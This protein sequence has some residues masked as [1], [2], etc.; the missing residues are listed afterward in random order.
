MDVFNDKMAEYLSETIKYVETVYK[1][2]EIYSKKKDVFGKGKDRLNFL[3]VN[4]LVREFRNKYGCIDI[5]SLSKKLEKDIKSIGCVDLVYVYAVLEKLDNIIK[6]MS[7]AELIEFMKTHPNVL[8]NLT[9]HFKDSKDF[10]IEQMYD[11]MFKNPSFKVNPV[12]F[13]TLTL[14][15]TNLSDDDIIEITDGC[16][17][18]PFKWNVYITRNLHKKYL[19]DNMDIFKLIYTNAASASKSQLDKTN[20]ITK[21]I[22]GTSDLGKKQFLLR[23][24]DYMHTAP[25][26]S[27]DTN[28]NKQLNLDHSDKLYLFDHSALYWIF[29]F[30]DLSVFMVGNEGEN[31][32][33]TEEYYDYINTIINAY[34]VNFV[35]K[36]SANTKY[37]SNKI[38]SLEIYEKIYMLHKSTHIFDEKNDDIVG[39]LINPN[40]TIKYPFLPWPLDDTRFY[41]E[42]GVY[43]S[44]IDLLS[45]YHTYLFNVKNTRNM[46][47]DKIRE[48]DYIISPIVSKYYRYGKLRR[49]LLKMNYS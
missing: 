13:E 15:D 42:F 5:I 17:Y 18:L 1:P 41:C 33:I 37:D 20:K 16:S 10:L 9:Y 45:Q 26:I 12:I 44:N 21:E 39:I 31:P 36:S 24:L 4:K 38:T 35:H 6:N 29:Q 27:N 40:I 8:V 48:T 43:E 19:Y 47:Y 34:Y 23:R 7:F 14:D 22:N 49:H 32:I 25:K 3:S 28:L 2:N 46:V 30:E 11:N